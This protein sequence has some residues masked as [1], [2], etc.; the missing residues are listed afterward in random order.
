MKSPDACWKDSG[1]STPR[2]SMP[3]PSQA[4]SDLQHLFLWS[5]ASFIGQWALGS[6]HRPGLRCSLILSF[7]VCL[8]LTWLKTSSRPITYIHTNNAPAVQ[9]LPSRWWMRLFLALPPVQF[10]TS[11]FHYMNSREPDSNGFLPQELQSRSSFVLGL[12]DLLRL[13]VL[14]AISRRRN[15]GPRRGLLLSVASVLYVD[16][17]LLTFVSVQRCIREGH[18]P[19]NPCTPRQG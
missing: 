15:C 14:A 2:P 4:E 1:R 8:D 5:I 18:F 9:P 7:T 13:L 16:G 11:T 12:S 3:P 19:C 17:L 10:P 6:W